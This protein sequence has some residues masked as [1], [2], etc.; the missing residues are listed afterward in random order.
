M[1]AMVLEKVG[2][3]LKLQDVPIP[4]P[5]K[6]EVLV[7]VSTCGVCR[8]DLHV[9]EGDLPSPKLPLIPGHQVIGKI[10]EIGDGVRSRSVGERVGIPWL[11]SSCNHCRF[12]LS[13]KENLC[14]KAV[15]TGYQKNGGYAEFCLA[16]ENFCFL[17][18]ERYDDAHAAP[19]V[20][21]GLI[22]YRSYRFTGQAKRI[23]FYGF[24]S[25]AHIL[26][27]VAHSQNREVF[28]FTRPGDKEGQD[29]AKHLGAIWAGDSDMLP[30]EL[31]DAVILF[32]PIGALIP[33]ALKVLNK[34]GVV[35]CAGIH[36]TDIPSFPYK[37]LWEERSIRSVSNL[38][39]HDAQEFFEIASKLK[40]HVKTHLYPLEQANEALH[41]LKEGNISGTNVLEVKNRE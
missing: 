3:P 35:V 24:G 22:G 38:T 18:P 17:I 16:H 28:V 8:T 37:L 33:N 4:E 9:I 5:G 34:G 27:Q 6:G 2:S 29:F 36:M 30:P 31:L 40:I 26:I 25:S 7:Q 21:A 14:D 1:R 13:G 20:C 32:A 10:V 19:L 39:R 41:S 11:G 12:C 15:Y 23:G